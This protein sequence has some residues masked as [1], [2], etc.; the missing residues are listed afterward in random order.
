MQQR[1][2]CAAV[3]PSLIG[4]VQHAVNFGRG[5]GAFRPGVAPPRLDALD[6]TPDP[7]VRDNVEVLRDV[8][9][10]TFWMDPF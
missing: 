10:S 1:R 8:G 9:P 4:I 7:V 6:L 3:T 2:Q 5:V